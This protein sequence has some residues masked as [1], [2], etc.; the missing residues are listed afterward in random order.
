[1][2][3]LTIFLLGVIVG[4]IV[5]FALVGQGYVHPTALSPRTVIAGETPS[6]TPA[7]ALPV[8]TPG[9]SPSPASSATPEA[10]AQASP[11]AGSIAGNT[12]V[13]N[14]PE[15]TITYAFHDDGTYDATYSA[16]EGN[17]KI[18]GV[19]KGTW[20]LDGTQLRTDESSGITRRTEDSTTTTRPIGAGNVTFSVSGDTITDAKG[21]TYQ[22]LAA[23]TKS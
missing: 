3:G 5:M 15:G 22:P 7:A 9:S 20:K 4:L 16:I 11:A 17:A 10:S 12:Y 13:W 2:K 18:A 19:S 1:M 8:S 14:G 6:P 21:R 23:A